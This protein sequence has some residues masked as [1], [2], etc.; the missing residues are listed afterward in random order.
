[1]PLHALSLQP[2]H[3][4]SL[5]KQP[6]SL[7]L[8]KTPPMRIKDIFIYSHPASNNTAASFSLLMLRWILGAIMFA[9]GCAKVF[10]WFGGFG[11]ETTLKFM[12]EAHFSDFLSY[13]NMFSELVGG[14]LLIMGLFTRF[15][16]MVIFINMVVA[17][18]STGLKNFFMGGA[19]Y[20]F[21]LAV[22][23]MVIAIMGS[24]KYS[25]DYFL[26]RRSVID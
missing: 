13:A 25:L 15:A 24:G 3:A 20:T 11:M 12:R 10:G 22:I 8:Q 1:M 21:T 9:G 14:S 4:L 17:V 26:N 5:E 23:A 2:P 19:A 18:W 16:A 7:A 6:H